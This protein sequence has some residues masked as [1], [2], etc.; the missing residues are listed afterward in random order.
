LPRT[1]R[2]HLGLRSALGALLAE[3]FRSYF[4]ALQFRYEP[5]YREGLARYLA[6]AV[7]IG[8]LAAVP[9]MHVFGERP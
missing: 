9:A 4:D 8:E 5:R 7:E 1:P 3:R 6:E 2:R